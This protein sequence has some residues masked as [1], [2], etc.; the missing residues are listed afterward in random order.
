MPM[1]HSHRPVTIAIDGPSGA[2]KSTIARMLAERLG[3]PYLDT[4][5]MYRAIGL[6]AHREGIRAPL[7]DNGRERVASIAERQPVELVITPDGTRVFVD[8]EDLSD[9]IR[10]GEAAMMAS[11]VSA[12]PAVRRAL[13][14]QQQALAAKNGGVVEGRDIGTV[15]LPDADLKVFLTASTNERARRRTDDLRKR[16][17]LVDVES[18]REQQARRDRQDSTRGASPLQVAR[19]SV[20]V[21]TTE[22]APSAVVDRLVDELE[23]RRQEPLDTSGEK[24][25]RSR[26]HGS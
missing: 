12:V 7:D 22:L 21:D 11:A 6:L 17:E 26:N 3:V 16:G 14:R 5:A 19:G 4:G 15:V 20:V 9:E 23:Y 24:P 2:G 13:V 10:S 8:G 1:S 18:V 25:V